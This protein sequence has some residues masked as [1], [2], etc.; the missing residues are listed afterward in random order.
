MYQPMGRSDH[1]SAE[2]HVQV[3]EGEGEC[4]ACH[5]GQWGRR[6]GVLWSGGKSTRENA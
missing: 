3:W 5:M 6:R 4:G 1:P 2:F